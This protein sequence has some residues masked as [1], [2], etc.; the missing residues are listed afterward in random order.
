MPD[1]TDTTLHQL[2]TR[3]RTSA[4]SSQVAALANT[5]FNPLRRTSNRLN[6]YTRESYIYRWLTK[7]PDP[8]VIVIDL[9]E[10]YTVGPIIVLLDALSDRVADFNQWLSPYWYGST[11][12]QIF[13]WSIQQFQRAADTRT[14]RAIRTLLE[15][16]ERP[17]KEGRD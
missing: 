1:T 16:P 13:D 5:A 10:T 12:N 6:E 11:I 4:D 15:P 14:G 2:W 9:R 7:E 3:L 17:E 8:E